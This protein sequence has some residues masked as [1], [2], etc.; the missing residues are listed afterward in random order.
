MLT[1]VSAAAV[2]QSFQILGGLLGAV[3]ALVF[4]PVSWQRQAFRGYLY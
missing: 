1:L 2:L 4:I 3:A